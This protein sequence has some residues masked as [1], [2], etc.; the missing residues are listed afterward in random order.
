LEKETEYTFNTSLHIYVYNTI[1]KSSLL[2][3]MAGVDKEFD[4]IAVP[5]P[6]ASIGYLPQVNVIEYM[7]HP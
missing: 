4:G 3:I 7:F 6:G 1:G 5:M 2:K